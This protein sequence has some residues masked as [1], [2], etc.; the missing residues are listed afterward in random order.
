[1]K[2]V[3]VIFI[4][5]TLLSVHMFAESGVE[6]PSENKNNKDAYV[7]D[8]IIVTARGYESEI[9]KIPG[10]T[11]VITSND[12]NYI[13]PSSISDALRV[14]PGVSKTSDSPWGSEVNI[15]GSSRANVVFL[16]DDI[17]LNTATDIGAQFGTIDPASVERVEILKGP[18]SALYG[19]GTMGGV[20]NVI[21]KNGRFSDKAY[22][23]G[24]GN[25]LYNANS[26]G[27]STYAYT[28]YNTPD[29]YLFASGSYRDFG[30][31]TDGNH[32]EMRNSGFSDQQGIMNFGFKSNEFNTTELKTQY[33]KGDEIGIPGAGGVGFPAEATVTYDEVDRVLIKLEHTYRPGRG[34]YHE[35]KL[36]LS[37]HS[38]DRS[39]RVTNIP[40]PTGAFL[41]SIEPEATH[42]TYSVELINRFKTDNHDIML[43]LDTWKRTYDG[44]RVRT[45]HNGETSIDTPIPDSYYLSSGIYTEDQWKINELFSLNI[46]GR[47]DRIQVKNEETNHY[48]TAFA[49]APPPLVPNR[50]LWDAHDEKE[51][52]WNAHTGV[53]YTINSL[54]TTDLIIARAYRAASLEERFKYINLGSGVEKWGNP[55][56]EPE[57][58][59]FFEYGV[60]RTSD[61]LKAGVSIYYNDLSN[62]IAENRVSPTRIELQNISEAELYGGEVEFTLH[63][64]DWFSV[65]GN[66]AYTRGHD[67]G[68]DQDLPSI[69]PVNGFLRLCFYPV[70]GVWVQL[71]SIYNASQKK[72]PAGVSV[73]DDWTRFDFMAG[74]KFIISQTGHEIYGAV[75]NLFNS[76]YSDYL[77]TSRGYTFN[78]PGRT[79]RIG[80]RME[81]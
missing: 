4:I 53:T 14:I 20:V 1:M 48:E 24:G 34:V 64:T 33:Y 17:R 70:A 55:D 12:I 13:Q 45:K 46:G 8:E 36:R 56:L 50:R 47:F 42:N 76:T 2:V 39:V 61:N 41:K 28:A 59:V 78:E 51:Y 21:T 6:T 79:F 68:T 3:A 72:V 80:Y 32:H 44:E 31:Y 67:T 16:V 29:F 37:F 73:S 62:L 35:S 65:S 57:E 60:K 63:P 54:W 18:I 5:F 25:L 75:D 77:T 10:G 30:S 15:R 74:Y 58:S 9:K 66:V 38:I 11:G 23:E 22:T 7:L 26:E 43:G 71:D 81:F 52:S 40:L 19:S 49:T 27:T 69:P